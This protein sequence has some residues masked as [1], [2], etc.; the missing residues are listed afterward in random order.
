MPAGSFVPLFSLGET[1]VFATSPELTFVLV[2]HGR[3]LEE[4]V[5][6]GF[7]LCSNYRI[8]ANHPSGVAQRGAKD[9]SATSV[10]KI[11]AY[12]ERATEARGRAKANAALSLVRD[13]SRSPV[14]SGIAISLGMPARLGGFNL[15]DARMNAEVLVPQSRRGRGA[16]RY[17][18]RYPDILFERI[19]EQGRRR[20]VGIDYDSFSMHARARMLQSDAVRRNQLASLGSFAHFTITAEQAFDFVRFEDV[21]D[22]VRRALALRPQPRLQTAARSETGERALAEAHRR[23]FALWSK[24]VCP[25]AF[26]AQE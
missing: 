13:G 10:A 2:S 4:I 23:R 8:D 21:A 3:P 25:S 20:R 18:R 5:Y 14:E 26:R 7:C 19:D 22:S 6:L 1:T 24:V 16:A 12:L 9:A 17:H 11:G 15:G